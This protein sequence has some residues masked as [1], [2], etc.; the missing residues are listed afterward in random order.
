MPYDR[1]RP[2]NVDIRSAPPTQRYIGRSG[3]IEK[4]AGGSYAYDQKDLGFASLHTAP[5]MTGT[6]RNGYKRQRPWR[7]M[8]D[9]RRGHSQGSLPVCLMNTNVTGKSSLAAIPH[10]TGHIQ[11]KT[12]EDVHAEPFMRANE[13][14]ACAVDNRDQPDMDE[15]RQTTAHKRHHS[16]PWKDRSQQAFL[17]ETSGMAYR[18]S[19]FT[20]EM[21]GGFKEYA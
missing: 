16:K 6:I 10:Y 8:C 20:F 11:G 12:A 17:K 15:W 18:E 4:Q 3:K 1:D 5:F 9:L 13:L 14:A 2:Q 21:C 7:S 19:S